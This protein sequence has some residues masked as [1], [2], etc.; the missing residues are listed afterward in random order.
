[1]KKSTIRLLLLLVT[2]IW[3]SGYVV[4]DVLLESLSAFQLL[5]ARF[6]LTFI[7][8]LFVFHAKIKTINKVTLKKGLIL[9]ALLYAAFAFQTVGLIYTTPSKNAFLTQISVVF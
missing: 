6:G 7:M 1:M 9:G 4:N 2:I 8:L 5:T 3:G